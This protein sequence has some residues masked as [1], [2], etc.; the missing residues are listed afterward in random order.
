LARRQSASKD[1]E[2]AVSEQDI[3]DLADRFLTGVQAG[4]Q[5]GVRACYA[6]DAII[7]HNFDGVEQTVDQNMRSL[8]WFARTLRDRRYRILRRAAIKDG[9]V[10]QHVLEA[11]LPD[12]TAWAM[13]ACV[14]ATVR[15]GLIVRLDEY[16][17]SAHAAVLQTI[18]R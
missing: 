15:D 2:T 6:P 14:V 10:Q 13:P 7:W 11:T 4:D 1:R 5:D 9:F 8:R 16:L 3:L 17:D 12:G 18:G